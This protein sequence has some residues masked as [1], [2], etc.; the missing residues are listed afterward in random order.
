MPER[1]E[2]DVIP[3][4]TQV[5]PFPRR[6]PEEDPREKRKRQLMVQNDQLGSIGE[7][8]R[9][10]GPAVRVLDHSIE[11]KNFGGGHA[12]IEQ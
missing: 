10:R 9:V 4:K 7:A 5:A 1:L 2:K 11:R 12:K 8:I 6:L 3:Q